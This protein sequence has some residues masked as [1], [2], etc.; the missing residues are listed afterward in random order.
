MSYFNLHVL[1]SF[2]AF[3]FPLFCWSSLALPPVFPDCFVYDCLALGTSLVPVVENR[4]LCER[5]PVYRFWAWFNLYR[6]LPACKSAL[7]G[8]SLVQH[9]VYI[10]KKVQEFFPLLSFTQLSKLPMHLLKWADNYVVP[11]RLSLCPAG[12]SVEQ[13]ETSSQFNPQ[14][15]NRH[16]VH[17][18]QS[19]VVVTYSTAR[20]ML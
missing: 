1:L 19:G 4:C 8:P 14:P 11:F 3:P 9:K 2:P 13:I 6:S 18:Y 10:T 7:W 16:T 17:W 5:L 12:F 20:R 15:Y